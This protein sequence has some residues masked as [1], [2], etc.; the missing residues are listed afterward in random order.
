MEL[1][2]GWVSDLEEG[3]K[4]VMLISTGFFVMFMFRILE[5]DNMA[6]IVQYI[7][8]RQIFLPN[9]NLYLLIASVILYCGFLLNNYE[10]IIGIQTHIYLSS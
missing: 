10:N 4:V 3:D 8:I 7:K 6:V 5:E 2:D 9:V 1:I